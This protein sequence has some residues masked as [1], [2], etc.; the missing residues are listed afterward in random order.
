MKCKLC[1]EE[2]EKNSFVVDVCIQCQVDLVFEN[3][4]NKQK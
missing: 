2:V 4:K 1:R 3:R